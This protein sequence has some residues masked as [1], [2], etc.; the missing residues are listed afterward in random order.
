[1]VSE[2]HY[3][4]AVIFVGG[5]GTRLWPLSRKNSPKQF[6]NYIHKK[7]MFQ[8]SIDRLVPEFS[9]KD[10][11]IS[12]GKKYERELLTQVPDLIPEN[13]I[14][15]PCMLD[16]GPAVGLVAA[17]FAK[18]FPE[19]PIAILW[20]GDHLVND[21]AKF[22]K[23]IYAGESYIQKNPDKIV[24]F[25]QKPRFASPNLGWITL[26]EKIEEID[27]VATHAFESW[28]YRP[29]QEIADKYFKSGN[30]VWNPGYFV[31]TSTHLWKLFEKHTPQMHASLK[32]IQDAVDTD[33]F[34]VVLNK[35]YPT[36]E[37]VH[38]DNAIIEKVPAD[39]AIVLVDD[40]GWSDVGAWEQLKE[41]LEESRT[42]NVERGNVLLQDSTDTLV[43]N[44]EDGK[45]IVGIDLEGFVVVNTPDALLIT[46]KTSVGKVKKL[47]ESLK[48]SKHEKIT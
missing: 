20:G 14:L 32:I 34:E 3:M 21:E 23:M 42:A 48:G 38:F 27:G 19:E 26:G 43:F 28:K 31:V 30:N 25:G 1:M 39:Q 6:R 22:R 5:V 15:E 37:K 40:F 4:K 46:K 18:K 11:F 16:V 7:T 33:S 29:D 17:I 24:F 35:I 36:L 8:L 9:F 2:I 12:T 44:H 47:I 41:A 45:T 10:I 13:I